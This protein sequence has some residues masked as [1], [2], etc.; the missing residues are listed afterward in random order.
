LNF[1]KVNGCFDGAND[2]PNGI[3][4]FFHAARPVIGVT[5]VNEILQLLDHQFSVAAERQWIHVSQ[6]HRFICA[7]VLSLTRMIAAILCL[8]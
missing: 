3:N 5:S 8:D 7:P 4:T 1:Q 2:T 6:T